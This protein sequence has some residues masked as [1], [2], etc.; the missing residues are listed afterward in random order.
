MAEVTRVTR[1][2]PEL[3]PVSS[4][5][6]L[7]TKYLARPHLPPCI[8]KWHEECSLFGMP[9]HSVFNDSTSGTLEQQWRATPGRLHRLE[10]LHGPDAG[11][12]FPIVGPTT[13]GTSM[14]CDVSL[15]D[16]SVSRRHIELSPA[17]A[18]GMRL[19][20]ASHTGV[21]YVNGVQTFECIVDSGAEIVIGNTTLVVRVSDALLEPIPMRTHFGRA[22]GASLPMRTLYQKSQMLA[23]TSIPIAIE[24]EPGTGK[25]LIARAIHDASDRAKRPFVVFDCAS[26]PTASLETSI[27]GIDGGPAGLFEAA[28]GG[29]LLFEEMSEVSSSIQSKILRFFERQEVRRTGCARWKRVDVRVLTSIRRDIEPEIAAGRF[30]D[31]LYSR[32]SMARLMVPPLRARET[33]V[34]IIAT[35]YWNE[36]APGAPFPKGLLQRYTNYKWPGN[37]RE[38]VG[39]V[40]RSL[41]IGIGPE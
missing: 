17:S 13:V 11:R 35:H 6:P 34:D 30:S 27:F 18:G 36:R 28:D 9:E 29:T 31:H 2:R 21:V 20:D 3:A 32:L 4:R 10:V 19:C 23:P 14:A 33:D 8:R 5:R 24:G 22:I 12:T 1:D 15:T 7:W 41:S 25:K 37:V 38:L 16:E 26:V 40:H 39:V